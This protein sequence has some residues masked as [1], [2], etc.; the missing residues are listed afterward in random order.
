[1]YRHD[2]TGG[3]ELDYNF[4]PHVSLLALDSAHTG[5]QAHWDYPA[6]IGAVWRFRM[7]PGTDF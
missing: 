4:D 1:V 7:V 6:E 5:V 3:A 2:Y